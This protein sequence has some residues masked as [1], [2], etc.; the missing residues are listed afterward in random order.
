MRKEGRKNERTNGGGRKKDRQTD[1]EKGEK[2]KERERDSPPPREGNA[3]RG[4]WCAASDSRTPRASPRP[5]RRRARAQT[6]SRRRVRR[7]GGDPRGGQTP[8]RARRFRL[9]SSPRSP[10]SPGSLAPTHG[11]RAAPDS[12][13]LALRILPGRRREQRRRELERKPPSSSSSSPTSPSSSSSATAAAPTKRRV[14]SP[15]GP[16]TPGEPAPP[17]RSALPRRTPA[18]G[19]W[20]AP[21]PRRSR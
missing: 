20:R 5:R 11:H 4:Y 12:V 18:S 9:L 7:T 8:R 15:R 2:R 10:V 19:S 3:H 1:R 21:Q 17:R 14:R 16:R 6:R 13:P